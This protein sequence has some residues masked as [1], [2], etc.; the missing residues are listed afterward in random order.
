VTG[1]DDA[2]ADGNQAFSIV[3]APAVSLDPGYDSLDPA[4]VSVTN[5]D[6][7]MTGITVTPTSR[8]V[9]T[10]AGG[11][12]TFRVSLNSHPTATV[13][14]EVSSSNPQE[15]NVSTSLLTFTAAN[16]NL[17]QTVTVT[18]VDDAVA[19]GNQAFSIVLAPAVSSDSG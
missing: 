3:L 7:D 18:G 2:V 14:I 9:T 15:G 16:W 1:V 8:L 12:A 13:T 10:E 6:N 17:A 4:D 11:A 5:L 19:D